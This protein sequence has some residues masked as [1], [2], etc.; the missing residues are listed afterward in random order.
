MLT[1]AI[2]AL[3]ACGG[4]GDDASRT[5]SPERTAQNSPAPASPA[6]AS[7]PGTAAAAPGDLDAAGAAALKA[8]PNSTL[9]SI[10]TE[11]SGW[12]VQTVTADGTE[13]ELMVNADG[14]Q[15]IRND[16]KQED[17]EDK[18]KHQERVKAAKIDYSEAAQKMHSA[19]PNAQITELNLDTWRGTTVWEG[20]LQ[21]S[22]GAKHSVKI[23]AGSGKVLLP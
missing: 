9:I 16:T 11:G 7:S 4:D 2:L 12:E 6:A 20:D 10:E 17:A 19:V 23:D 1:V 8:V 3:S 5:S 22:D 13:H 15:I 14:S 21:T 18:A